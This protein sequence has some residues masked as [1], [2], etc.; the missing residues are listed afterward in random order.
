MTDLPTEMRDAVDKQAIVDLQNRYAYAIDAGRYDE[1]N[2]VFTPDAVADYGPAGR[3]EGV[4][5]IK[6]TCRHALEPLTAAQHINTNHWAVIDGDHA[7]AGC[8]LH[9]HQHRES[10]PGGDHLEMGGRYEDELTRTPEG[11]RI[12]TRKLTILWSQGNPD[13]RWER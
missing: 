10:T 12:T 3:V 2:E 9:V 1:L 6:S 8:Y 4:E 7:R 13:V 11:W 5:A